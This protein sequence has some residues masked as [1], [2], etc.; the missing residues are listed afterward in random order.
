[1]PWN[2]ETY[3]QF[4]EIRFKPFFDL[5]NLLTGD[6]LVNGVDIGCGTG[7]QTAI[8]SKNFATAKFLGIDS[9]KEM[10]AQSTQFENNNLHFEVSSI[11]QFAKSASTWDLIFSNAA[12]QWA[13]EHASLFPKL[14]SKINTGGQFAV[15][16][17]F[18]K[19]N[20]LNKI[21]LELVNEKPFAD[22][23]NGFKRNSPLL[24]IDE[25]AKIMFDN[26]LTDITVF[27][28][29]YPLIAKDEM[30][31]YNFISGS[32]LIP[33]MEKMNKEQQ[34]LFKAEYLKRIKNYF[35]SFPAIYSFKRILMYG[36]KQ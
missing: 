28:K 22:F 35:T 5:C 36:K 11:E 15:Q 24:S 34:E 25:Y 17:P 8:L 14:I 4:K 12:L 7:E 26:G 13:D 20:V 30:E 2:A 23:L 10:L 6:G 32:S 1:M 33:Y 21:L 16:M 31:L 27:L 3:L 19:E 9:S 29:I 18:Q